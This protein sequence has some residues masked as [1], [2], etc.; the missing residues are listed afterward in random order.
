MKAVGVISAFILVLVATCPET[1][2]GDWHV[3]PYL[4]CQNCHVQHATKDGTA[5]PGGPYSTLLLKNTVNE[6]CLSCHDGSDPT[7]PDVQA[8]VQMYDATFYGESSAG[9]FDLIAV[10][11]PAGHSLGLAAV[12]PLQVEAEFVELS[13]A[14]CHAVHGNQNYRNLL[15]DP[16]NT[17]DSLSLVTGTD[18]FAQFAPDKPP[19]T[20]GSITAYSRENIGFKQGYSAWCAACHNQLAANATSAPPAHFNSHPNDVAINEFPFELHTDP[21]HWVAGTGEGFA[22]DPAGIERVPFE[23]PAAVDFVSSSEPAETNRIFCGSC[24][25]AHGGDKEKS[26]LWSYREGDPDYISG[27]QQC[28]N[29]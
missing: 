5:I 4:Y 15:Y 11:N 19:T 7:A 18:V 2:A 27:C 12:I 8:P 3:E 20:A 13:C 29:K 21:V 17:G 1:R 24:H 23:V 6:L 16:A 22:D 14:S 28:H 9:H 26:L 10:D 25:K